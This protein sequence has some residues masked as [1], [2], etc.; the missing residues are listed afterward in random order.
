MNDI[1]PTPVGRSRSGPIHCAVDTIRLPDVEAGVAQDEEWCEVTI[2]GHTRRIRFHDYGEIYDVPG[3][4]EGL[5]YD[6][7]ECC[8]PARVVGLLREVL[9]DHDQRPENLRVLDLGAGNGMVGEELHALGVEH[10][11][12]VDILPEARSATHRDRPGI[13]ADYVVA[14][15]TQL[16][17]A[18]TARMQSANPNC[19]TGVATLGFGDTPPLAFATALNLLA[20]PGWLAFN[21]KETFLNEKDDSGFSRLIRELTRTEV[22]RVEAYR[23]Y[24]HRRSMSGEPL[25]YV[26][27]VARKLKDAPAQSTR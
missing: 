4:Y 16:G 1:V 10:I 25:H 26:A 23:R 6:R 17:P 2:E 22:I 7:L 15:L 20:T 5:F 3:L 18:H 27:M 9:K 19:L 13:Y 11:I 24:R 12:G 14:D 8:S 21:I